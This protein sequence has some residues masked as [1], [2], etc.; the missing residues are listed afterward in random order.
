MQ[1]WVRPNYSKNLALWGS[2]TM[3]NEFPLKPWATWLNPPPS[4]LWRGP[5]QT[6][7][8]LGFGQ[9][10]RRGNCLPVY[11]CAVKGRMFAYWSAQTLCMHNGGEHHWKVQY[12]CPHKHSTDPFHGSIVVSWCNEPYQRLQRFTYFGSNDTLKKYAIC[13]FSR[14]LCVM[15]IIIVF[16]PIIL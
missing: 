7:A 10:G 8:C 12:Y 4:L 1:F 13:F 6:P 15:F 5:L 2:F 11:M 3:S 16:F 9:K 14:K